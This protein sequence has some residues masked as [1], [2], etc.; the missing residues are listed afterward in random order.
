MKILS[1]YIQYMCLLFLLF[2]TYNTIECKIKCTPTS[3]IIQSMFYFELTLCSG[4]KNLN[5]KIW[6][7]NHKNIYIILALIKMS[8]HQYLT[9]RQYITDQSYLAGRKFNSRAHHVKL[10]HHV[11]FIPDA[12]M[13]VDLKMMR[14]NCRNTQDTDLSLFSDNF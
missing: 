2:D 8:S 6:T 3:T 9:V 12:H 5:F 1:K 7:T 10:Y 11:F 14:Q 4:L 13:C